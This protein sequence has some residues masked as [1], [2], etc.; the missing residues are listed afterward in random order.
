KPEVSVS[1]TVDDILP[2]VGGVDEDVEVVVEQLQVPGGL[3]RQ[4]RGQGEA[5][6]AHDA[7]ARLGGVL[8][9]VGGL[10]AGRGGGQR[11]GRGGGSGAPGAP[12][13]VDEAG[14]VAR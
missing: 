7:G 10:G 13:P 2:P 9:V 8:A 1:T 6:G 5:L 4:H 11:A 12:T 3:L 14:L